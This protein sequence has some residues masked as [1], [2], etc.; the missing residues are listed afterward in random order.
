M[1]RALATA[2]LTALALAAALLPLVQGTE[3]TECVAPKGENG[4]E[5]EGQ[6][7]ISYN[8]RKHTTWELQQRKGDRVRLQME[9]ENPDGHN[10]KLN[11][12]G[13]NGC[14]SIP[15]HRGFSKSSS[16][17]YVSF[18]EMLD[19]VL[20]P[21]GTFYS[22]VCFSITCQN[23][24]F[25]CTNLDY[26][27]VA[28]IDKSI[29]CTEFDF[30]PCYSCDDDSTQFWGGDVDYKGTSTGDYVC[31]GSTSWTNFDGWTCDGIVCV[32]PETLWDETNGKCGTQPKDNDP[33]NGGGSEDGT[34]D[35]PN[36]GSDTEDDPSDGTD[37]EDD[38][39]DDAGA[40][41]PT[42]DD[43]DY[44]S[45][46]DNSIDDD[47]TDD[48]DDGYHSNDDNSIDDDTT[49]DDSNADSNGEE[50]RHKWKLVDGDNCLS[51]DLSQLN[52]DGEGEIRVCKKGSFEN[53]VFSEL[54]DGCKKLSG[55]GVTGNSDNKYAVSAEGPD[56]YPLCLYLDTSNKRTD[57]DI[58]PLSCT[59]DS[60]SYLYSV[61]RGG[62]CFNSQNNNNSGGGIGSEAAAGVGI[63]VALVIV[64]AIGIAVYLKKRGANNNKTEQH[65]TSNPLNASEG[66]EKSGL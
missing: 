34:A 50:L 60:G 24:F 14:T 33:N 7:I 19:D 64:G 22:D 39:N 40:D 38:P 44:H 36:D 61:Q 5:V 32:N 35:D 66:E 42:D 26:T 58:N 30:D 9:V 47:P 37:N 48:D 3:Y 53:P 6:K 27:I 8:V 13:G 31:H 28:N 51:V 54:P 15:D 52:A 21:S 43:S 59:P 18:Q 4:V 45:N 2:E 1:K 16:E 46:D 11:L 23:S 10:I 12:W 57:G 63:T 25:W 55:T 29:H 56:G 20:D 41:D 62:E 49:D 17:T 65:L